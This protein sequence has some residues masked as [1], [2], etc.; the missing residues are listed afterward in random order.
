MDRLEQTGPV[1]TMPG[2]S[3]DARSG[4][5]NESDQLMPVDQTEQYARV[6]AGDVWFRQL[7][8]EVADRRVSVDIA[9]FEDAGLRISQRH[10]HRSGEIALGGNIRAGT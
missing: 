5:I 7:R 1:G 2:V 6:H 4:G 8:S 10:V 3:A 9:A